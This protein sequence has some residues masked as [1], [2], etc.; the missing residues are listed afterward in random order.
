MKTPRSGIEF[1]VLPILLLVGIVFLLASSKVFGWML[2]TAS[3]IS[4]LFLGL[5]NILAK[6]MEDKFGK[7]KYIRGK[8][9]GN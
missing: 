6:S 1:I 5:A 9:H 4:L 3:F 8:Q 7:V 2:I